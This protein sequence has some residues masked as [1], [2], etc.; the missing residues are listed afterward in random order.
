LTSKKIIWCLIIVFQYLITVLFYNT[1]A[2]DWCNQHKNV[3]ITIDPPYV[4]LLAGPTNQP[5]NVN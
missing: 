3:F 5:T 1:Y 2:I 4:G